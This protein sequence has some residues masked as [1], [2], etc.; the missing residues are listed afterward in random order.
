[1]LLVTGGNGQLGSVLKQL[2]PEAMFTSASE[3]DITDAS[4]VTSFVT[5]HKIDTVINCA[6]YT[7]VDKAEEESQR[8][9]LINAEGPKNLALTGVKIIHVSTDYVFDGHSKNPYLEEDTAIPQSVYGRSKLAGEEAVMNHA[10]AAIII[11]TSWLYSMYGSNFV[12]TIR[13]LAMERDVLNVVSDQ[14]GSP[15]YAY[16]LA[17]VIVRLLPTL[18]KNIQQVYHYSNEGACSWYEF[19]KEIVQQCNLPCQI[20]PIESKDYPSNAVR[21]SYAVMNT[22]KIKSHLGIDIPHWKESLK[23]CLNQF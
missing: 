19:A 21:P 22:S 18:Q 12:K 13:T 11:R 4:A 23:Q 5:L 1:M 14:I 15:T 9:F 20:N 6:A 17:Q 16:D 2:L 8:A 10:S 7:H 3:L